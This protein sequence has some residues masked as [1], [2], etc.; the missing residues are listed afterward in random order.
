MNSVTTEVEQSR[1]LA[2]NISK[3][4]GEQVRDINQTL[5]LVTK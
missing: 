4:V 1:E 3:D 5:H 2:T